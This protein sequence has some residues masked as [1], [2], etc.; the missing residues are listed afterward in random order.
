MSTLVLRPYFSQSEEW[1]LIYE[2]RNSNQ[3]LLQNSTFLA[4]VPVLFSGPEHGI[5]F[6]CC[7]KCQNH[8]NTAR[9]GIIAVLE[10]FLWFKNGQKMIASKMAARNFFIKMHYVRIANP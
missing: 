9:K 6:L 4:Y 10:L 8:I 2:T 3:L 5:H 1:L 7:P